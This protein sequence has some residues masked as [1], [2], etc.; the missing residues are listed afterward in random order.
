[1]RISWLHVK[2]LVLVVLVLPGTTAAATM[3]LV[4][5]VDSPSRLG[6]HRSC[7]RY[8]LLQVMVL[9]LALVLLVLIN[10]LN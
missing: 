1:M 7:R 4:A 9:V 8:R 6:K 2:L 3:V 5:R 10:R